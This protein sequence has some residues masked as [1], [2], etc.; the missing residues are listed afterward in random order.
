MRR[1]YR[2]LIYLAVPLAAF[3]TF[4]V[5]P[6]VGK[7]LMPRYGGSA[8]TWLTVSLFFQAALL[9]GYALAFW[10]LKQPQRKAKKIM[11]GLAIA[12]PLLAKLPPWDLAGLPEWP[13]ILS[14]LTLSLLPALLLTT[15][16]G[17]V[18][19]GWLR[20]LGERVPYY[21]YGVSNLGSALALIA[22]PF[23]IEPR[24]GLSA[25]IAIF[26]GMLSLLGVAT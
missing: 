14:G 21:L 26:R 18:L 6:A 1:S 7:L 24:V 22:Y 5:Q 3:L 25:Q 9:S 10:L 17:V 19:Q 23:W 11:V 12:G 8:G 4:L 16:L 20:A 2:L 15:S 13:A